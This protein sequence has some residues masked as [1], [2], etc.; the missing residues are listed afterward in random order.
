[1][2]SKSEIDEQVGRALDG[3]GGYFGMSYYGEGVVAA[4]DWVTGFI[5]DEPMPIEEVNDEEG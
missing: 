5:D 1:M 4:L 2:R 3:N